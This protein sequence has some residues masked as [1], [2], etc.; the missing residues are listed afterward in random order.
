[1][2]PVFE[3]LW[4]RTARANPPRVFSVLARSPVTFPRLEFYFK[5]EPPMY[6]VRRCKCGSGDRWRCWHRTKQDSLLGERRIDNGAMLLRD[7]EVID[8]ED[9]DGEQRQ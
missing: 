4:D 9:L 8:P 2:C 6:S 1:M 5:K 7:L 3:R